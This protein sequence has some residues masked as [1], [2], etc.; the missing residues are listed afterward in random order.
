MSTALSTIITN[1]QSNWPSG[2]HDAELT[3][4][5]L[6]RYANDIQREICR[7]YNFDWMK[8]TVRRS[9]VNETQRYAVPVAGDTDWTEL[10]GPSATVLRF[11]RDIDLWL[12]NSQSYRVPLTKVHKSIL[13]DKA[14][15]VKVTGKG[16]PEYFTVEQGKIWLYK[17]PDHSYNSSSAW[18]M[19][20][21]FFGY[22]ADLA[23]GGSNVITNNHPLVLEYGITARGYAFAKDWEAA[24]YWRGKAQ[25][26]FAEMIEEDKD[27]QLTGQEEGFYPSD[28]DAIGGG[29]PA[30][31][32][33]QNTDWYSG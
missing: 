27:L 4:A 15:L 31:G 24:N 16:I 7:T 12:M 1:A 5:V 20:L 13:E 10:L 32:F 21:E 17:I 30:T 3:T 23:S 28:A 11:K 26:I 18:T 29:E 8:Q 33:L 22:L 9:T 14:K 6:V 25:E 19:N 2:F